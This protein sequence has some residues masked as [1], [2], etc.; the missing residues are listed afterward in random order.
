MTVD[1]VVLLS[2]LEHHLYCPRKCALI[3][4]DGI[5]ADN[6]ATVAG[7][8]AHRRVDTP[9]SRQERGRTVARALP[10]HS[11]RYGLS[12]RSDGIEISPDGQ[13]A[14]IEH[15]AGVRHG[16]SAEVQLGAQA[17]CLEE[18]FDCQVP[19]GWLW[20]GAPRRRERIDI[21]AALRDLTI[22][23]IEEIRA[24]IVGGV[25][26]AP[27]NDERCRA[28]QLESVC[29]PEVVVDTARVSRH[30]ETDVLGCV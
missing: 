12:G 29:L 7:S 17:L 20:Y 15:K 18:M 2:A 4:V 21:D 13:L 8:R 25:L 19:I 27:V 14:P 1:P 30:I 3:H 16:R 6:R 9:G 24:N 11:E 26:P 10:L 5:W 22:A 23:T 28:C